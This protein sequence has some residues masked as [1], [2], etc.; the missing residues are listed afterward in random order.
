MTLPAVS[1]SF[2]LSRFEFGSVA[3]G[4]IRISRRHATASNAGNVSDGQ[5]LSEK[6]QRRLSDAHTPP[7]EV[8]P[9]SLIRRPEYTNHQRPRNGAQTHLELPPAAAPSSAGCIPS[10]P[11][12]CTHWT[13]RRS[14]QSNFPQ[15]SDRPTFRL[16]KQ[17]GRFRRSVSRPFRAIECSM[18]RS[19]DER[20][21]R[22]G[23]DL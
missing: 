16:T 22:E 2:F 6:P 8:P 14:G 4:R 5:R 10:L 17:A 12:G 13:N 19:H 3:G 7:S 9:P 23:R 20:L 21:G 1:G 15:G 18:V 11:N